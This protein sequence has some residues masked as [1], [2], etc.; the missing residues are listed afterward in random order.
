MTTIDASPVRE[1]N[2]RFRMEVDHTL[3]RWV[4]TSGLNEKGPLFVQR[5]CRAVQTF[6]AFSPDNDPYGEHD[7]ATLTLDNEAIIWKIDTYLDAEM[8]Y[9]ADHPED[10]K[11]SYRVMTVMLSS[12][13]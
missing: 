9:A 7:C 6:T 4:I 5:A 13:Y 1:L 10:P 3:G 12:E 11:R 8:K 2:D